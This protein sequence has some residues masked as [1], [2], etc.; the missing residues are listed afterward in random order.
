LL[1]DEAMLL[2]DAY[3]GLAQQ[4]NEEVRQVLTHWPMT[5]MQL[6]NVL[7]YATYSTDQSL[8]FGGSIDAEHCSYALTTS[9]PS[10]KQWVLANTQRYYMPLT[11]SSSKTR[12]QLSA[13]PQLPASMRLY[14]DIHVFILSY[15]YVSISVHIRIPLL[16]QMAT[17]CRWQRSWVKSARLRI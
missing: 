16:K 15:L 1:D 9:L 10:S 3:K 12:L 4:P 6:I 2:V 14:I 11:S 17:K 5:T 7:K 13:A 8:G